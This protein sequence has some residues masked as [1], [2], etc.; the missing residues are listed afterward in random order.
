[1]RS[2]DL[3]KRGQYV[4]NANPADLKPF[5]IDKKTP[6]DLL[7]ARNAVRIAAWSGAETHAADTYQKARMLLDQAEAQQR[8]DKSKK[9]ISTVAAN[10]SRLQK[11]LDSSA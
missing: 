5:P 11:M 7:Q 1:M 8:A 9:T 10:L 3:L 4:V 2:F 6:L